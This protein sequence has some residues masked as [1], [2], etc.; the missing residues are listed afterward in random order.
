MQLSKSQKWLATGAVTLGLAVGAAGIAGAAT[1]S[2]TT[3]P[4]G[5]SSAQAPAAGQQMD[6][7]KVDHG[8]GET[9]LTGTT[10]AKV[11]AAAEAAVPGG[12]V[13]RVETD[14]EGSPYEAHVQKSDGTYVTVKVDSSFKVTTTEDGFGRGPGGP[15]HG[16]PGGPPPQGGSGQGGYGQAP[17]A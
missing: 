11:K 9:L 13:I 15:G 4:S 8:P 5:S 2:S 10:S 12:T 14:N 16:G 1:S 3:A 6:P 17:A 7:A